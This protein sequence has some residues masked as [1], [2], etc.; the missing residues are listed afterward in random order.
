[1]EAEE[2]GWQ[3]V[4]WLVA[5]LSSDLSLT[6][7]HRWKLLLRPAHLPIIRD[8]V[9]PPLPENIT[10]DKIFADHLRYIK[11]QVKAY[12]TSTYGSGQDIWENLSKTMYLLLTTPNGWEGSQ[13]NRMRQA[14]ITAGF[15][16]EDGGRRVKF[17][18]E[19]E[20]RSLTVSIKAGSWYFQAAVLYAADSGSVEDWLV[21]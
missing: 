11:D 15:V 9:L 4:E 12:I 16:D 20:V 18:T 17:V 1:M 21:V 8:L 6:R 5:S 14:A 3:K 7:N 2:N 10:V 13:Q 19:A